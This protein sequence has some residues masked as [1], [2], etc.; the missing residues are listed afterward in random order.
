VYGSLSVFGQFYLNV[1]KLIEVPRTAFK[2]IPKV[3]SQV[4][5]IVPRKKPMFELNEELFFRLV[6]S[7]FWGR[8]KSLAKCIRESPFLKDCDPKPIPP[9]ECRFFQDRPL[10]RGEDLSIKEFVQLYS[11]LF[12]NEK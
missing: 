10:V 1:R 4:I 11:E 12:P 5:E 7:A 3:E 9:S 6:R 8:R 2:P